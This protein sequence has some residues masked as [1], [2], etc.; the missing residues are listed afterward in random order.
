[1]DGIPTN[2]NDCLSLIDSNV[3]KLKT[4]VEAKRQG[5]INNLLKLCQ[6]IYQEAY[7]LQNASINFLDSQ[8]NEKITIVFQEKVKVYQFGIQKAWA[9]RKDDQNKLTL[10]LIESAGS[11][12]TKSLEKYYEQCLAEYAKQL[13]Y[14]CFI[15][16]ISLD[17]ISEFIVSTSNTS[18]FTGY[19]TSVSTN[20]GTN[21]KNTPPGDAQPTRNTPQVDQTSS[22]GT[23]QI[24][25][26]RS[27]LATPEVSKTASNASIPRTAPTKTPPASTQ[28]AQSKIAQNSSQ[29]FKVIKLNYSNGLTVGLFNAMDA[30]IRHLLSVVD[31]H[32]S[33]ETQIISS[34]NS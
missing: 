13:D 22:R 20:N 24:E 6:T 16:P 3:A 33:Q 2:L 34:L 1:M 18:L 9:E 26:G 29:L 30:K 19:S 28:T 8:L 11:E 10:Q 17:S 32:V 21:A 25:N 15:V 27:V 31:Y 14:V 23:P 4:E 12:F 5:F 7:A